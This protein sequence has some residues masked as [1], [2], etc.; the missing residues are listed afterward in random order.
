MNLRRIILDNPLH[1]SARNR[2]IPSTSPML[3]AL[4]APDGSTAID[5]ARSLS[6]SLR[7]AAEVPGYASGLATDGSRYAAYNA[8]RAAG[9]YALERS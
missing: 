5:A 4:P 9:G 3:V 6:R 1:E 2:S 7:Y 8:K